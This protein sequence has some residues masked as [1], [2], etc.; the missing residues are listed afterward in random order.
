MIVVVWCSEVLH[1]AQI[2]E[3]TKFA[4]PQYL[5][6]I[7]LMDMTDLDHLANI[8]SLLDVFMTD[9]ALMKD[10][11]ADPL[12]TKRIDYV[13]DAQDRRKIRFQQ[14]DRRGIDPRWTR[15]P[16]D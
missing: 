9:I 1:L 16:Y 2:V 3:P 11:F 8:D 4:R 10:S 5:H 6:L 14:P 13:T 12:T 7:E 15:R